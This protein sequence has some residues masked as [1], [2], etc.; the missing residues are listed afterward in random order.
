VT[1][2]FAIKEMDFV[3]L[4]AKTVNFMMDQLLTQQPL[5][6]QTNAHNP[7]QKVAK[8]ESAQRVAEGSA[9]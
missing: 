4:P 8:M 6:T 9:M 3:D 7:A 1:R 2:N 5:K